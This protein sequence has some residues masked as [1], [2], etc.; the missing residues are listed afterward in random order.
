VE[1]LLL[2]PVRLRTQSRHVELGSD[3]E[4]TV[5]AVPGRAVSVDT[6]IGRLWEG[7]TPL[8]A[9][10]SLH[11]YVSR[12]RKRLAAAGPGGPEI[13]AHAHSYFLRCTEDCVDWRRFQRLVS[14]RP[15]DNDRLAADVLA[16]ASDIWGGEPL[17]GLSGEWADTTRRMM[18]EQRLRADVLR[19][20]ALLRQGHFAQTVGELTA[21][22]DQRPGDETIQGLLM[23]AYHGSQRSAEA[24]HVHQRLRQTL[25]VEYGTR[26]GRDIDRLHRGVLD[27]VPAWDLI[28]H[29]PASGR[30]AGA[31]RTHPEPQVVPRNLPHQPPLIG[32]EDELRLLTESG[33]DGDEDTGIRLE[34]ITGMAGVGKTALA[35]HTADRLASRYPD[36]QIYLNFRTHADQ[37]PV[38]PTEAVSSLLRLLGAAV[39]K[40]PA[41]L[42]E[43]IALWHH[44]LAERRVV[45][46]L[47]D[48]A[49]AA[50]VAP[51]LPQTRTSL[52]IMTSRRHISGVPHARR[53]RLDVLPTPDAVALFRRFAGEDR[54]R[55]LG[56]VR[57]IVDLAGHLPLAIELVASRMHTR[58]SWTA[59]N[60]VRHLS[61]P[62]RLAEIRDPMNS[63]ER[64]FELSYRTLGP[65]Q[66]RAFRLLGLHLGTG[67]S[68][69]AAAAM[70]DLPTESAER[71]VEALL[72]CLLCSEPEPERFQYHDL[73]REY[74]RSLIHPH[75]P[76]AAGA[77]DR[78][79]AFYAGTAEAADRRA[80]PRRLRPAPS[81]WGG[82]GMEPFADPASAKAWLLA[83]RQ[84][85]LAVFN[86]AVRGPDRTRAASLGYSLAGFLEAECHWQEA[87]SV[88]R[89]TVEVWTST[90]AERSRALALC[91]LATVQADI[92]QYADSA[93]NASAALVY[94]RKA[95]DEAIEAEALC[96]RGLREWHEGEHEAAL[97]SYKA[98]LE[99]KAVAGDVWE[100]ARL[101]NNIAVVNLYLGRHDE[102]MNLLRIAFRVFA[103]EG[104][105]LSP[106]RI[107]TNI[108]DLHLRKGELRSAQQALEDALS[109]LGRA[110][111]RYDRATARAGLADVYVAMGRFA[112]ALAILRECLLEFQSLGDRKSAVETLTALAQAQRG[113][114]NVEEAARHQRDAV[115]LAIRIGATYLLGPREAEER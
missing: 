31:E 4:R 101:T 27:R 56:L 10:E 8:H 24:I 39:A 23:V 21:L 75:D 46:V 109:F 65:E 84:N 79:S 77:L 7:T 6:L 19:I 48:I 12:L 45:M 66:R 38:T 26:P 14:T 15:I 88:L 115:A 30:P 82:P 34:A 58:A 92:G 71:L 80:Y 17:S 76:D 113:L 90:R 50:Q 37:T 78:L 114:G 96:V 89:Q 111:N 103:D 69:D 16:K 104:D 54:T 63:L 55:D 60:L 91:G 83:E 62:G 73:L 110:G 29:A 33:A 42:D 106:A 52:A 107:L 87:E 67:F 85:L 99:L 98:A 40:I 68:A 3:K 74:A 44:M 43:Q 51:L 18:L 5:L 36:A 95:G 100:K 11:T 64:A 49:D 112:E 35:V 2:G 32:R 61:N 59:A 41:D 93:E 86:G 53:I 13:A 102:A 70:L 1:I 22:A 72:A 57:R 25:A 20:T 105:E 28:R 94:A 108:G 9:R 47:D 97:E 81:T